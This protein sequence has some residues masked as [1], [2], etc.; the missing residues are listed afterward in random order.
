MS[1]RERNKY[2]ENEK[3]QKQFAQYQIQPKKVLFN[4]TFAKILSCVND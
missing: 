3:Y 4:K 1:Q 2:L